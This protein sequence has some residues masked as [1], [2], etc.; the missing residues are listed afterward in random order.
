M[1]VHWILKLLQPLTS[2]IMLEIIWNSFALQ[3]QDIPLQ[4]SI[5][6]VTADRIRTR[7][8]SFLQE[9]SCHFVRNEL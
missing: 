4:W 3:A 5:S 7:T 9:S 1:M 8:E 2:L 6:R